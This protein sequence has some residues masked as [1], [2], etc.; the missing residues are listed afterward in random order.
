MNIKTWKVKVNLL[1]ENIGDYIHSLG[2]GKNLLS[3][4]KNTI[5][6]KKNNKTGYVKIKHF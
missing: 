5:T 3:R 2:L 6:I 1:E 4:Y